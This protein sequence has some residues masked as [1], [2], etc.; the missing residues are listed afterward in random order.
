MGEILIYFIRNCDISFD[1]LDYTLIKERYGYNRIAMS[2]SNNYDDL[3][4]HDFRF[5]S[6]TDD[7]RITGITTPVRRIMKDLARSKVKFKFCIPIL[8]NIV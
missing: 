6:V 1:S 3:L 5:R 2:T 7:R 8:A 4:L